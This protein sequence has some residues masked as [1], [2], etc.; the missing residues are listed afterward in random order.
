MSL[1]CIW[2]LSRGFQAV[3]HHIAI[4]R[5]DAGHGGQTVRDRSEAAVITNVRNK[6]NRVNNLR[7]KFFHF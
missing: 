6:R 7:K 4:L 5:V 2:R 1:G 3:R